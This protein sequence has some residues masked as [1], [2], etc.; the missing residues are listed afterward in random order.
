M[1][2]HLKVAFGAG[3]GT[4]TRDPQLGKLM[5]YQLS[6]TRSVNLRFL[7]II[8]SLK[9]CQAPVLGKKSPFIKKVNFGRVANEAVSFLL[10]RRNRLDK[11]GSFQS[12][13]INQAL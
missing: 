11:P 2:S 9:R 4:R 5:L 10:T 1:F 13:K 3:N 12:F 6:Y 8:S 7:I